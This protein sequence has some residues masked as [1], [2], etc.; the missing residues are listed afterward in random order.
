MLSTANLASYSTI[1][2]Q[3][4]SEAS[5]LHEFIATCLKQSARQLVRT[6]RFATSEPAQA[7]Y[8]RA[9]MTIVANTLVAIAYFVIAIDWVWER[10]T[11]EAAQDFYLRL[12]HRGT[13]TALLTVL[14]IAVVI[15]NVVHFMQ[16]GLQRLDRWIQ[17]HKAPIVTPA[18]T[19]VRKRRSPIEEVRCL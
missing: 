1:A 5:P 14:T 13:A 12:R 7:F 11:N 9:L 4:F 2:I 8:Q 10:A 17:S 6:Y 19:V 16:Q 3:E 15:G 18:P